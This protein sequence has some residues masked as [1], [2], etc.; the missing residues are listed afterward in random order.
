[1]RPDR[2][3]N[4]DRLWDQAELVEAVGDGLLGGDD[5]VG[6]RADLERRAL[7]RDGLDVERNAGYRGER[8]RDLVAMR[9]R[10]A[11]RFRQAVDDLLQARAVDLAKSRLAM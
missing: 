2:V 8:L 1:M 3:A 9:F 5:V 10:P 11:R 7:G 4:D 6:D